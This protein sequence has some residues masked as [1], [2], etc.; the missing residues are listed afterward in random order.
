MPEEVESLLAAVPGVKD[1]AVYARSNPVTGVLLVADVV[2]EGVSAAEIRSALSAKLPSY[3]VPQHIR[4]V[5]RLAIS[6]HGKK[7]RKIVDIK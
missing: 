2:A 7:V 5:D 4:F 6:A 1:C 3:K